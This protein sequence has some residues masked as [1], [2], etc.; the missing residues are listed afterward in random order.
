MGSGFGYEYRYEFSIVNEDEI[1]SQHKLKRSDGVKTFLFEIRTNFVLK[2]KDVYEYTNGYI[3][4]LMAGYRLYEY[5]MTKQEIRKLF[6][7]A[8]DFAKRMAADDPQ[9]NNIIPV[10]V[11]LDVRT[12]QQEGESFDECME[13]AITAQKLVPLWLWPS[14]QTVERKQ[15]NKDPTFVFLLRVLHRIRVEDVDEGLA[16]MEL[17]PIC[18]KSPKVGS[19]ISKLWFCEHPFH[20]HCIVRVLEDNNLC[21][22]CH[23]PVYGKHT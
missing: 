2:K 18:S 20:S 11:D 21:P 10:V 16:L 12:V 15:F 14:E 4:Y 22:T 13:R 23:S 6:D 7:D 8:F 5:W 3:L 9:P 17:C 1:N 19:Q